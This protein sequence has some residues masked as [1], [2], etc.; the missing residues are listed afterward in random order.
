MLI[1]YRTSLS[2]P[3]FDR[4]CACKFAISHHASFTPCL[5][6]ILQFICS[7]FYPIPSPHLTVFCAFYVGFT[8][9]IVLL[10]FI[11]FQR[12]PF[13]TST[14]FLWHAST[15]S[16]NVMVRSA[17]LVF[18]RHTAHCLLLLV[19]SMLYA[20]V[21]KLRLA[22]RMRFF[23]PLYAALCTYRKIIYLFYISIANCRNIAKLFCGSS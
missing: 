1:H 23:E 9:F 11:I 10:Y 13:S 8:L 16:Y 19:S 18:V 3:L 17:F 7:L 14:F 21:A 4:L 5:F 6:T 2:L 22:S 12:F 20:G 15:H